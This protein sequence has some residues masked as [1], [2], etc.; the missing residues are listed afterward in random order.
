MKENHQKRIIHFFMISLIV[1]SI[2]LLMSVSPPVGLTVSSG[3]QENSGDFIDPEPVYS[4]LPIGMNIPEVS[5]WSQSLAFTDL[6]KASSEM[7]TFNDSEWDSDQM[8]SL[9]IDEDG[10]PLYLPQLTPDEQESKIRIGVNNYYHGRFRIY[11]DG[12]GELDG[13]IG[14]DEDGYYIDLDGSGENIWFNIVYSQAGDYIRNIRIVP[15]EYDKDDT[16]PTFTDS[17]LEGLEPFHVLRFMDWTQTNASVE[18]NWSDRVSPTYYTQ[19]GDN[20]VAYEYAIEMCNELEADAWVC[21]PHMASDEYIREMAELWR[22]NLDSNLKVYLEYSNEVWNWGFTQ[23]HWVDQNAPGSI[24]SYISSDL[25]T[26][27]WYPEKDAYMMAR[28]FRIW[29]SVFGSNA[30]L[31][32]VA[33]GQHAW[34]GNSERILSYL[35]DVD[36]VGC[37]AFSVG[38]YFYYDEDLHNKWLN[39]GSNLTAEEIYQ[40]ME[41]S[42]ETSA[43]WTRSSAEVANTYGV[44]YLVYEGGQHLNPRDNSDSWS[45]IHELWDFQIHPRMYDLYMHNFN[46]HIEPNVD[47]KLFVAYTYLGVRESRWGSWGHLESLD[48]IEQ[49]NFYNAPKYQ[50]LLDA[51]TP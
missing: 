13:Y 50:A 19:A 40:D 10:Y 16:Y 44:D 36:G 18:Q 49:G 41:S 25:A 28:V 1:I 43:E 22:D 47:C 34:A 17:Y 30:R 46:V 48:Q 29:S 23:T 32:R 35:F 37:D 27:D 12:T 15:A 24:D 7:S 8:E 4:Q 9:E 2:F 5:Y 6:M 31:V 33:T 26:L 42:M 45:Y 38:G 11:F 51:N 21:V 39:L 14:E 3:S 20:G